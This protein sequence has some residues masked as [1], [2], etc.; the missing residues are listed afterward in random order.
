VVDWYPHQGEWSEEDYL[1][2]GVAR[3]IEFEDGCLEFLPMPTPQ[4]QLLVQRLFL[5]LNRFVADRRLG[6]VFL[7]PLPVRLWTG[8]HREADV[9]YL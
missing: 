3:L 8:K 7:A 1:G 2:L 4:H 5:E 6:T 9:V